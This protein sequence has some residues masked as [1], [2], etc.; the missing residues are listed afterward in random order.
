MV[1]PVEGI[2]AQRLLIQTRN[3]MI[4]PVNNTD[5]Q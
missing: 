5:M 4:K 1:T 2:E 3:Y